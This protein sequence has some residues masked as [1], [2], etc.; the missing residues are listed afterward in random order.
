MCPIFGTNAEPRY[1]QIALDIWCGRVWVS[2][3]CSLS[4]CTVCPGPP[5]LLSPYGTPTL[6]AQIRPTFVCNSSLMSSPPTWCSSYLIFTGQ[7]LTY[8]S[9]IHSFPSKVQCG[10]A[11]FTSPNP[12]VGT[13]LEPILPLGHVEVRRNESGQQR[14]Y[15]KN[16]TIIPKHEH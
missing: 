10:G 16:I 4:S 6:L 15:S 3:Q 12:N 7:M 14:I 1:S 5:W 11:I 8:H 2:V 13:S 9:Q